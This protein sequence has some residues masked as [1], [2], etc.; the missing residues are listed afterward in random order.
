MRTPILTATIAA[1]SLVASAG[2]LAH[3]NDRSYWGNANDGQIWRN[4]FGECWQTGN[5]NA[6]EARAE[7]AADGKAAAAP[8]PVAAPAP[9]DTSAAD[10]AA[11]KAK[12]D[13][14]AAAAAA[15][16]KAGAAA[17]AAVTA[18]KGVADDDRDGVANKDD[19]CPDTKAG[20]KVTATGC[21]EVLKETV[22][23][24]LHVKF[25]TG[26]TKLDAA[27]SAETKKL[28]DFLTQYPQTS[29]EVGGH[30][31]NLGNAATNT[32]LSQL[33]ADAVR[34]E[35][36]KKY[37]IDGSRVTAKGYGS[38]KPVADNKTADGRAKNRRVEGVVNQVVEKVQ[39]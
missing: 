8:A 1:L 21:Y 23:I 37:G 39:N 7:C 38:D 14:E 10:A 6:A 9:A 15:K 32:R 36:I 5:F 25:A 4:S 31:D 11:A 27:G 12:A 26:S 3:D 13:A 22:T 28:A 20:A 35:L 30:T 29:I 33:R 17:A 18:A 2:T 16:A 19:Q 24:S 34:N